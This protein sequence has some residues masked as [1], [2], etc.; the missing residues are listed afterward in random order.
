MGL[1]PKRLTHVVMAAQAYR[2]YWISATPIA[3]IGTK[4]NVDELRI[5]VALRLG[6]VLCHPH[7]CRCCSS[8]LPDGLHPFSSRH[9]A[10]RFPRHVAINDITKRALSAAGFHFVLEPVGLDLATATDPTETQFSSSDRVMLWCGMEHAQIL[11]SIKSLRLGHQ[12]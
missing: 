6:L 7:R 11:C 2:G 10:G 9:S 4:L 12:P 3:Q 1:E 5:S 8:V